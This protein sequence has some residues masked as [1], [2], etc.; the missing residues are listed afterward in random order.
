MCTV[1]SLE[2]VSK[3]LCLKYIKYLPGANVLTDA[4]MQY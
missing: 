1:D 4:F 3:K 2:K